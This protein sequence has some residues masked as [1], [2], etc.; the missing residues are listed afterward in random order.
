MK[1]DFTPVTKVFLALP[2]GHGEPFLGPGMISL[3]DNIV[4]TGNVRAACQQMGMSYSKGWKLLARL[5]EC[6]GYQVVTKKQGG[7][8]GGEAYLNEKG[9]AF[10]ENHKNFLQACAD[11][12]EKLFK[13]YY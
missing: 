8:G 5:D 11:S 6:L 9:R 7:N 3:L 10:L 4:E 1:N 13:E 2:G 12:V